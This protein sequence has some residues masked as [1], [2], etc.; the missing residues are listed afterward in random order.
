MCCNFASSVQVICVKDNF[1]VKLLAES[2]KNRSQSLSRLNKYYDVMY[3]FQTT[4]F[5]SQ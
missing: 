4:I 3:G 2:F 1:F 5:D